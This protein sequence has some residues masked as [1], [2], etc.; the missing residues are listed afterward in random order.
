MGEL[1]EPLAGVR[2]H[3]DVVENLNYT[4]NV[5]ITGSYFSRIPTRGILVT[6]RG[7]VSIQRNIIHAPLSPALHIADD[8]NS[9]FKSGPITD[10]LFE[11]NVVLRKGRARF[12]DQP[13]VDVAPSNTK[14]ATVHCNLRL[15]S[16]ELHM[17]VGS[18]APVVAAKS[19]AG[20]LVMANTIHSPDRS[21]E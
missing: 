2:L 1:Q 9:W 4:P 14:N 20:V 17:H 10:V 15:L 19:I 18:R 5:S 13:I 21:W 6:T 12:G 3:E 7:S 11:Q 8:A 16:N